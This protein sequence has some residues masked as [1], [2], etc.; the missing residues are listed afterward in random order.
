MLGVGLVGLT[1]N[2]LVFLIGMGISQLVVAAMRSAWDRGTTG[3]EELDLAGRLPRAEGD[4]VPRRW[5]DD[6]R[7]WGGDA[8]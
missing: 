5:D 3:R 8:P 7:E 4:N 6:R 2:L 1:G